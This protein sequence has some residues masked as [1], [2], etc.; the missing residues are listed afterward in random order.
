M[1]S[2]HE[3][4]RVVTHWFSTPFGKNRCASAAL[5][6][7]IKF[8]I[9]MYRLAAQ[10]LNS[11]FGNL[12]WLSPLNSN[13]Q[14]DPII[15]RVADRG[16]ALATAWFLITVVAYPFTYASFAA[17]FPSRTVK[18]S[19]PLRCHGFPSRSFR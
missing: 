3:R 9:S 17:I 10:V 8:S 6:R 19:I 5:L 14:P 4:E 2:A 7:P 1:G 12:I 13:P 11:E 18:T 16:I 15:R